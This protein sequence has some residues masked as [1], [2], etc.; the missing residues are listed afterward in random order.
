[1]G[2]SIDPAAGVRIGSLSINFYG[3][4]I[5]LG[6]MLAVI[7]AWK[8]TKEF[9]I[10]EDDLTD[11]VLW[12]APF[13]II[14][15]RLYYCA[16]RW[17][18]GGYAENPITVLYIWKGG[19]AIYGAVIGAAI[20]TVI[21]CKIKKMS[22]PAVLDLVALG[23][24]IGQAIGRWGNF[25]NREAYGAVTDSVLRMGLM[26]TPDREAISTM[27]YYHPTFFYE[28][29]W[30]MLGFLVLYVILKKFRKFS[31]QLFLCYG[32]WYG[33]GRTAIEGLRTDSLYIGN[34]D[35]RVSQALSM[36]I[37]VVCLAVM[38]IKLL[39]LRKN[40]QPIEGVD[41]FPKDA[42]KYIKEIKAEKEEKENSKK[43]K[44][45]KREVITEDEGD[46]ENG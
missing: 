43:K 46:E 31:G 20:G 40:P 26:L 8:R 17:D 33:L 37:V 25:F 15:A 44:I 13:A 35:I 19:L 6:L 14:C 23:F 3:V 41:F 1:L 29:A 24:L 27:T 12:I 38:I 10:K 16:F 39:K 4:L 2:I 9:G 7:Y 11:G 28:F 5:A 34:T 18:E 45:L 21:H 30:C 32:I 22:L 42:A 36:A